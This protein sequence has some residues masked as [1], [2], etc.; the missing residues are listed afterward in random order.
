[1]C[2]LGSPSIYHQDRWTILSFPPVLSVLLYF[3]IVVCIFFFLPVV[4]MCVV[5]WF[6]PESQAV[7]CMWS[8]CIVL[9]GVFFFSIVFLG[10]FL[11]LF[12]CGSTRGF[13]LLFVGSTRVV[14]FFCSPRFALFSSLGNKPNKDPNT[15]GR[16]CVVFNGKANPM[17]IST[18]RQGV[19]TFA[20]LSLE[21]TAAWLDDFQVNVIGRR[22]KQ[23]VYSTTFMLQFDFPQVFYLDWK[24]IDEIQFLPTSGTAHPG[25]DYT[26][27]YFAITWILLG[28]EIVCTWFMILVKM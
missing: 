20:V 25:I 26:E 19:D 14:L 8:G 9:V 10:G 5:V 16:I 17:S 7:E 2:L 24:D 4:W 21:L 12:F 27:K 23:E 11:F 15:N 1:M 22:N 3:V 18:K 6:C 28:W 13:P